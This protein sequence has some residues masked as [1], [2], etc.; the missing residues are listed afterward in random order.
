MIG[1]ASAENP[2]GS[3]G[4]IQTIQTRQRA[5]ATMGEP[6]MELVQVFYFFLFLFSSQFAN[7]FGLFLGSM[8]DWSSQCSIIFRINAL[9]IGEATESFLKL[10]IVLV[11]Y[12]MAEYVE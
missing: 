10:L 1:A 2:V 11:E 12:F 7:D 3:A 6:P 4:L 9:V 5:S 8:I